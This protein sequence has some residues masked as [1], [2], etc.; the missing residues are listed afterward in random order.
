MRRRVVANLGERARS[1]TAALIEDDDA[2][3]RR[4][5]E[6][7]MHRRR[8]G[9][10]PAMQKQRHRPLPVPR[11]FPIHRMPRVQLELAGT[12]GLDWREQV[13]AVRHRRLV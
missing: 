1:P 13:A 8:T 11:L 12:V 5:E 10:G 2:P 3:E 4:V 9:A 6:A 7:P